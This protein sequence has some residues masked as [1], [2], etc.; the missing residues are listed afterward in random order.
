[1]RA[2]PEGRSSS[3]ASQGHGGGV[4]AAEGIVIGE[5]ERSVGRTEE[6]RRDDARISGR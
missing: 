4:D 3:D 6:A 2:A 1:M 5:A